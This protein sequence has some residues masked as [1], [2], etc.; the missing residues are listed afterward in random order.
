[1]LTVIL[2]NM[3]VCISTYTHTDTQ[4]LSCEHTST[5]LHVSGPCKRHA[6]MPQTHIYTLSNCICILSSFIHNT[7]LS[8]QML[9]DFKKVGNKYLLD[10][11]RT[12]FMVQFCFICSSSVSYVPVLF[13]SRTNYNFLKPRYDGDSVTIRSCTHSCMVWLKC[14][15]CV[16]YL[17]LFTRESPFK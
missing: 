13:W 11:N 4:V 12:R 6:C 17:I 15:T 7:P 16:M 9:Q 3:H 1:M 2:I 8:P 10:T 5:I 14:I